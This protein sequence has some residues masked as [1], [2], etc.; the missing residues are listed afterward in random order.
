M[1][2]QVVVRAASVMDGVTRLMEASKLSTDKK[3]VSAE[4]TKIAV[5]V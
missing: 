5:K 2:V 1:E 4:L 3:I